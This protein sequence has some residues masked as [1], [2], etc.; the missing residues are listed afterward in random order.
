V[1]Y[2]SKILMTVFDLSG[3]GCTGSL[4]SATLM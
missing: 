2:N 3:C 4:R 1:A